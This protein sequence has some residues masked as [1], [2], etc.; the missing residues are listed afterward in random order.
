MAHTQNDTRSNEQAKRDELATKAVEAARVGTENIIKLREQTAESTRKAMQTGIHAASTSFQQ[1][2]DQFERALGSSGEDGKRLAER[3]SQNMEVVTRS[4]AVLSEAFQDLSRQW[5]G[6]VQNQVRLNLEGMSQL[7]QCRSVQDYAA[8][9]SDLMREGL[10]KMVEDG[11]Q[12]AE[13][14]VRA[15]DGASKAFTSGARPTPAPGA[16]K[17]AS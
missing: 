3:Y 6:L 10:Q 17:R 9:R 8:V 14:S 2:S 1:A 16:E 7:S 11:R 15:A 12:I 13:S 5:W 4:G